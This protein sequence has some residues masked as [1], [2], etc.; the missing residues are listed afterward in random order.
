MRGA[1]LGV[2]AASL[3]VAIFA[4]PTPLRAQAPASDQG[5][6]GTAAT[7]SKPEQARPAPEPTFKASV[8]RWFD[9]QTASLLARYRR[10]ET[11][12]GIA[13]SNHMQDS[14]AL[15]VRF[16]FDKKGN[17]TINGGA[18]T[19]SSFTGGWNNA[20]WGTGGDRV[21]AFYLKQLYLGAVPVKGLD[22]SFGGVGILRGESTE[23]TSY[24]NDGYLMGERV[25]VKRKTQ[26]YFDEI[27]F[28]NAYLG[29]VSA[30]DVFNRFRRLDE[31]NYRQF[32]VS[33]KVASWLG[34]SG[35]YT[36][37]SGVGTVRATVTA[38]TPGAHV[39]DLV[40]YE[41]YK[42]LG[43]TAAYGFAA[44][45]EKTLV[46][47]VAI[48]A[49]YADIDAKYGGLNADRFNKGRRWFT[50]DTDKITRD[51]SAS[52]FMT[53]AVHNAFAVTNGTRVDVVVTYNV[54]TALQGAGILR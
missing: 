5:K 10:I 49:G 19:G 17:Y 8:Q 39:I 51:L 43:T 50:Q 12:G 37:L 45:G 48:G 4:A 7:D 35:D 25:S 15:K 34:A 30:P 29:D 1:R 18:A 32:L 52:F 6:G 31:P 27:A 53:K 26:L 38:K 41:Q 16:K 23:I 28:T 24:D 20:G 21:M 40:R 42:R 54:L 36:R 46:K 2:L 14:V 11:S 47:R 3:S 13:T 33:K 22:L 9:V 44:Y